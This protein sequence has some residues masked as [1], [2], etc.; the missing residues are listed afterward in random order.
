MPTMTLHPTAGEKLSITAVETAN[1]LY[2]VYNPDKKHRFS[3]ANTFMNITRSA[4]I[5]SISGVTKVAYLTVVIRNTGYVAGVWTDGYHMGDFLRGPAWDPDFSGIQM[6]FDDGTGV[7][8]MTGEATLEVYQRALRGVQFYT[9]YYTNGIE[10]GNQYGV[11]D[12]YM[13]PVIGKQGSKY[14]TLEIFA[15]SPS[16]GKSNMIERT[17]EIRRAGL[18]FTDETA[19]GMVIRF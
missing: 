17:V 2:M 1:L 16:S 8:T 4:L 9:N 15:Y 19:G 13:G 18:V 7:L 11:Y 12:K 3:K 10:T 5:S 14:R 6:A